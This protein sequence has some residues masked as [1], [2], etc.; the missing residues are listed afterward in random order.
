MK[1]L[2]ISPPVSNIGQAAPS[3]STLA[4]WMRALGH[5]C[6]QWD[7]G[8]EAFHYFH[9]AEYLTRIAK[10]FDASREDGDNAWSAAAAATIQK[11]NTV[12]DKLRTPGIE[13]DLEAMVDSIRVI[14]QAGALIS[15]AHGLCR[16]D[17]SRFDIPGAFADWESL[18]EAVKSPARNLIWSYFTERAIPRVEEFSPGLI[19]ISVSYHSQLLPALSLTWL[20]KEALPSIAVLLG[21]AFLKAVQ[22]DL[23]KMP[24]RVTPADGICIG[25]GEP[26]LQ[27]Y[28]EALERRT[29][30]AATP[31]LL[32]P[33][34]GVFTATGRWAQVGLDQAPVPMLETEGLRFD[35]YLTPRYAMPLPIAR[36]CY[37]RRC[38]FCNISN[39]AREKYRS[40]RAELCISDMRVLIEQGRTDW[41]DFP[42]D[43][44]RCGDLERLA[45]TLL[46]SGIKTRWAAE[47]LLDAGLTNNLIELLARSGCCGLR[48]GLESACAR[49]L[50]LMDKRIDLAETARILRR[51]HECGVKTGVMLIV[52]FPTET[53]TELM[54]TVDYL[55]E[56]AEHID[57]LTLHQFTIA[58]GSRLAAQPELA[59]VHLLPRRAVLMPSLPYLHTNPVAMRPE[60]LPRVVATLLDDLS[61]V[62]PQSGQLWA[63]GIGGWLTFAA[64][65]RNGCD[66]F[67]QP[68]PESGLADSVD[69]L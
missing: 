17:Y 41:F 66:F 19:G 4:A 18:E 31:N 47:V 67:K 14:R 9:S 42:T 69:R 50:Q 30:P 3:I 33:R 35:D 52:G 58:P 11:I 57:F 61:D 26:T 37:W 54:Q 5:D 62:F 36:G 7:L 6:R 43:S 34:Q 51:C 59:G 63:S 65:C 45:T 23:S 46:D 27:A 21:G 55:R 1:I 56:Q 28:V 22:D 48:F 20:I 68:L 32:M 15:S 25:D 29:D 13:G 2:L 24:T 38:V 8:L 10:R 16:L 40:R 44:L 49:T 12:K 39:Q 64:S 53:Q 60:D